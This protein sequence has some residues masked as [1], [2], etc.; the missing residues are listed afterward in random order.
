[1]TCGFRFVMSWPLKKHPAL[2]QAVESGDATE[3]RALACAVGPDDADDLSLV[4]LERD[5]LIGLQPAEIFAD[6]LYIQ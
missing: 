3:E 2:V 1:M 5:V 6:A 4:H